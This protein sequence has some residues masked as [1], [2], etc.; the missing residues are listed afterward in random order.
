MKTINSMNNSEIRE[1]GLQSLNKSLGTDGMIR[2]LQQFESG[3]GDYTK[4]RKKFLKDIS[5]DDIYAELT[6]NK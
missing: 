1:K 6:K 2:F 5:I 4:D 3:K